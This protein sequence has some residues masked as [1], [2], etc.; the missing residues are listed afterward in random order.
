MG[1]EIKNTAVKK[2]LNY[3]K[4][5]WS[6]GYLS[7][8]AEWDLNTYMPTDAAAHHGEALAKA[9]SLS[10]T[11]L[12]KKELEDLLNNAKNQRNLTIAEKAVIHRINR[13]IEKNKKIPKELLEEFSRVTNKAHVAWAQAKK[14]NNYNLFAPYLEKII[15]LSI[16]KAEKLGYKDHIYDALID[17]FEEGFTNKDV[18]NYFDSIKPFLLNLL[19]TI[20]SSKNFTSKN[21]ISKEKYNKQNLWNLLIYVLEYFSYNPNRLRLDESPHPFTLPFSSKHSRITTKFNS[22]LTD[23]FSPLTSTIHEFGHAL[24]GLQIDPKLDFTP[25]N[26]ES[27]LS[28]GLAESQ[29]R[30]WENFIGRN[31]DF[32]KLLY[33]KII[34]LGKGFAKYSL[35]DYYKSANLVYPNLIRTEADEVT[36]HFHILIRYEIEKAMLERKVTVKELPDLWNA[37]YKEYLGVDVPNYSKGILQ[38]IHWS[39][40]AIGYF[41][42]YS[43]GT[44]LSATWKSLLENDLKSS[45]EELSK[46]KEGIKKIAKW[47]KEH[48]HKYGSM[49]TFK[50]LIKLNT[51]KSFNTQ[52][53]KDYLNKKYSALYP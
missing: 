32:L 23:F 48:I 11:L 31:K 8:L 29:S 43:T 35:D 45:V 1:I 14:E 5:I 16:K 26:G 21:P 6:L 22:D 42:T 51:N 17:E 30:F 33:P 12:L 25:L 39:M 28:F 49:Y 47:Q 44:V 41:P 38:D 27:D 10:Q 18:Q 20:K 7:A 2:L 52:P 53:W 4:N 15:N 19:A 3:Y 40:G 34:N 24:H 50:E 37:K 13:A 36:Y 9:S 46:S